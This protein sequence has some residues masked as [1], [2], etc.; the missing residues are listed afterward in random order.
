MVAERRRPNGWHL[1]LRPRDREGQRFAAASDGQRH[2][3]SFGPLDQRSRLVGGDAFDVLVTDLDDLVAALQSRQ[4]GR[5]ARHGPRDRRISGAEAQIYSDPRV[6]ALIAL[7]QALV[8]LGIEIDRV[9]IAQAV[10]ETLHSALRQLLGVEVRVDIVGLDQPRGFLRLREVDSGRGAMADIGHVLG[11]CLVDVEARDKP[12]DEDQDDGAT[13]QGDAKVHVSRLTTEPDTGI[14]VDPVDTDLEMHMRAG[15]P[16][17]RTLICDGVSARHD[18]PGRDGGIAGKMAVV[19]RVPVPVD[20]H[21]QVSVA[22]A[23]GVQ[24]RDTRVGRDDRCPI[25]PGDI[26]SGVDLVRVR[27]ARLVDLEVEARAPETLANAARP[28]IRLGPFEHAIAA[29][30]LHRRGVVFLSELGHLRIDRGALRLNLRV[31]VGQLRRELLFKGESG[32]LRRQILL[33]VCLRLLLLLE[34]GR[35]LAALVVE[36][37]VG[38]RDLGMLLLHTHEQAP[39]GCRNLLRTDHPVHELADAGRGQHKLDV[40]DAAVRIDVTTTLVEELLAHAD[41]GPL[42]D[43]G[44]LAKPDLATQLIDGGL[45]LSDQGPLSSDLVVQ[46]RDHR[47]DLVDLRDRAADLCLDVVELVL[48]VDLLPD[49]L[50]VGDAS[51]VDGGWVARIAEDGRGVV[52]RLRGPRRR[53]Q[54]RGDQ[55]AG[56]QA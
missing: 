29:S 55:Q 56:L 20:D 45:R 2:L 52:D 35:H 30:G 34:Q 53:G 43:Q 39:V 50:V 41:V 14:F 4:R 27:A 42:P 48:V 54:D 5:R 32:S 33:Q 40:V 47:V 28:A 36:L 44:Y 17:G 26:E 15:R 51:L 16:T 6:L 37:S 31:L 46:A 3:R 19:R 9:R 10:H 13:P 22:H 1:D 18:L 8:L 25:R 24:V 23:A 12:D 11:I 21:Q 49:A 7:L 38:K